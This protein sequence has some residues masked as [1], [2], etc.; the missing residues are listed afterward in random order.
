MLAVEALGGKCEVC[1]A[2]E[3]LVIHHKDHSHSNNMRS[4]LAVLCATHH[5]E[6]HRKLYLKSLQVDFTNTEMARLDSARGTQ[7]WHDFILGLL[8]RCRQLASRQRKFRLIEKQQMR[9]PPVLRKSKEEIVDAV[10][11][12]ISEMN[13]VEKVSEKT[14]K[15]L[16]S[17]ELTDKASK[18]SRRGH[19]AEK[20]LWY[21]I[22]PDLSRGTDAK[23][24]YVGGYGKENGLIDYNGTT[25]ICNSFNYSI[26]SEQV[27][28]YI[29]NRKLG[30]CFNR[31]RIEKERGN[32]NIIVAI[33]YH[34]VNRDGWAV[35]IIDD[36]LSIPVDSKG[37]PKKSQKID[38]RTLKPILS[39]EDFNV[40][41]VIP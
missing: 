4:N 3:N 29:E 28:G 2:I 33:I 11:K 32:N 24:T 15:K 17:K 7:S 5:Q 14:V 35:R 31:Y 40:K 16:V 21:Q 37:R 38:L 41:S 20:L 6:Y 10:M 22:L 36:P 26:P 25:F 8:F 34:E 13:I 39:L 9:S 30:G 19:E 18:Y 27:Y 23:V 12:R 1:G